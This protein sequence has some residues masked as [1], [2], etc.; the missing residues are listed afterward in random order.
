[1]LQIV[2]NGQRTVSPAFLS[3]PVGPDAV[4]QMGP[5]VFS[6]LQFFPAVFKI[7]LPLFE[8]KQLPQRC[9]RNHHPVVQVWFIGKLCYTQQLIAKISQ[10]MFE[11]LEFLQI[12]TLFSFAPFVKIKDLP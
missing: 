6:C 1:M 5:I 11:L 3:H 4:G 8:P 10:L 12:P 9:G 2:G 7:F